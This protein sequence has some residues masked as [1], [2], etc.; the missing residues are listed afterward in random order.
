MSDRRSFPH[1]QWHAR[2][3]RRLRR[4]TVLAAKR[5]ALVGMGCTCMIAGIASVPSPLPI[6]FVLFA[7]GLYFTARG[8]KMARRG[9]KWVRRTVPPFSRGLNGIKDRLPTAM[10]RFIERS[11]PGG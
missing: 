7:M 10:R 2:S 4:R 1:S 9:V 11:D 6:G 3:R 8:S 5:S